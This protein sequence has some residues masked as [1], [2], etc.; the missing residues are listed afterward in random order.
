[1]LQ[2]KMCPINITPME[3]NMTIQKQSFKDVSPIE[4]GDVPLPY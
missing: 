1:M 4:N 3:I 2:W